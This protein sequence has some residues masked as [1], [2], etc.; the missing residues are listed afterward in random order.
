MSDTTITP[1]PDPVTGDCRKECPAFRERQWG[2]DT[3][4]PLYRCLRDD[5]TIWAGECRHRKET[6]K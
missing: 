6:G 1:S 5:R 3:Y 4:L 2:E